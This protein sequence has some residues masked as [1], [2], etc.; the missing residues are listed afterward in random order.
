MPKKGVLMV[1]TIVKREKTRKTKACLNCLLLPILWS[2][3][4]FYY[5]RNPYFLNKMFTTIQAPSKGAR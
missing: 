5:W 1:V 3:L 2:F 4:E